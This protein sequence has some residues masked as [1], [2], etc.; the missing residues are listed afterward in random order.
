MAPIHKRHDFTESTKRFLRE[1]VANLC[2]NP[3]CRVLTMAS[4]IDGCSSSNVGVAA[5]ICAAAPGGPRYKLEQSE[6]DR[7]HYDNGIW[8]CTTC[9]RLI[10]VDDGSY[11]EALLRDWKAKALVYARN[12][13]GKQ[14]LPKE[15]IESK[16]LRNTLDYVSGKDSLFS[17]DVPSKMVGFIDDQLN[18]LD[19]RFA[20]QTNVV[21]GTT[22]RN[23]L[24]LTDDASFS[25]LMNEADGE[26]FRSS[27]EAMRETGKPIKLSSNSFKFSGSKLFEKLGS[28]WGDDQ[29][30]IIKPLA[31]KV[32]VDLY[33][34]SSSNKLL[35]GSFKGKQYALSRG[36]RFEAYAFNK[37]IEI[38]SFYDLAEYKHNPLKI[39][40]TY[41]FSL[42]AHLWNGKHLNQLPFFNKILMARETLQNGG[43]LGVG[44][45][46]NDGTSLEPPVMA[47]PNEEQL[48]FF[49]NFGDL[50]DIIDCYKKI[51]E[52]FSL[53]VPIYGEFELSAKEYDTLHYASSL[54]DGEEVVLGENISSFKIDTTIEQYEAFLKRKEESKVNEVFFTQN[55]F[56]PEAFG[57]DLKSIVFK[58]TYF[59]MEFD[60]VIDG[61]NV[62]LNI[63]PTE[64]SRAVSRLLMSDD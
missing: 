33:A 13:V 49:S 48:R 39:K 42:N 8:L 54:L 45:E 36:V 53:P 22:H 40:V 28:E 59:D 18:Q 6:E 35:L 1:N 2:S 10:D 52:K 23:I 55:N 12:N 50:I 44:I 19:G 37:L 62:S 25:I 43:V 47:E 29:K 51:S 60:A 56:L 41:N 27:L 38:S 14:L 7:R 46:F 58:R 32:T 30:L 17:P 34:M 24:P 16:A 21:N 9:S 20:V 63:K 64:K 3:D 26:E 15:D 61:E 57:V 31:K 11:P 5:H 4:Q